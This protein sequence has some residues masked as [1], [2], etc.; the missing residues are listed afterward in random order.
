MVG[1]LGEETKDGAY[2]LP[3]CLGQAVLHPVPGTD[4]GGDHGLHVV[5]LWMVSNRR[6]LERFGQ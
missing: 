2:H 6:D 5:C 4:V 1:S 3:G